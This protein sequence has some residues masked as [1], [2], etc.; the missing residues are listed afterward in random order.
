MPDPDTQPAGCRETGIAVATLLLFALPAMA[1]GL[2][3]INQPG[4]ASTCETLGLTLLYAGLPVSAALGVAFEAIVVA[5]PLDITMWVVVGFALARL[6][7]KRENSPRA[8]AAA[9]VIGALVYGLVL[10]LL[11]EI[12]IT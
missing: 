4:C 7:E 5:W 2:Y 6:A 10:S 1:I 9:A 11:V 12:A 3:M 8:V